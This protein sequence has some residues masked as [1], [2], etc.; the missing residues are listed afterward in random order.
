[1]IR[2]N[3]DLKNLVV[4]VLNVISEIRGREEVRE[5]LEQFKDFVD[6][7]LIK[8]ELEFKIL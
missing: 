1:M 2:Y 5:A 6:I 7:D 3:Q 8:G 4:R